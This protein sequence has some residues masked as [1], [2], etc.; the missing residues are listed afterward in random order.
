LEKSPKL[1][2]AIIADPEL[3]VPPLLYGGIERI[4]AMLIDDYVKLGHE[5]SL[6]AH[7]NSKT[8]AKLFPYKGKTSSGFSD[9]L[10]NTYLI[11][12]EIF[13][14]KYDIIHSFGRLI[15]LLPQ[16]PFSIP[17]LMSY[18]REPTISQILIA[19]NFAKRSSLAFTG[20][21]RYI[22]DQILP[23]ANA[24]PIYNG[25]DL[26]KFNFN[27]EININAPLVFLGRI[28]PI[29]GV[30]LAIKVAK[31][32]D[33]NLIIAGNITEPYMKYFEQEVKPFLNEKIIYIGEVDDIK[34]NEIL[35]SAFAFLMPIEWNEPFG[36]VMAEAMACGTPIIGMNKGSVP[37]IISPLINGFIC[38]NIEEMID[39]VSKTGKL[40]RR[41]VRAE[42]EERF[43]SSVIANQYLNLYNQL[44]TN[45]S[46][47]F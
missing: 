18:Q 33:K 30:H 9:V 27:P 8:K 45:E 6:F 22:S 15:Y 2:I 31:A 1:K 38:D 46:I 35:G 24:Y 39:A 5:V 32:T 36:I 16:M 11:N 13:S 28:E 17:K 29:K 34:K 44:I 23:Y 14:Y 21:S 42:A 19:K 41:M 47:N 37:E 20:C 10:K 26:E 25:V 40:D 4:I 3:A 12:K 43:S 7:S